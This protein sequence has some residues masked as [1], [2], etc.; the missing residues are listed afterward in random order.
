MDDYQRTFVFRVPP[1]RV[2]SA[3][4]EPQQ[5]QQWFT[6]RFDAADD[7]S[8]E[9]STSESPGGPVSFEVVEAKP[10]ARLQYRQWA[11][12]PDTGIDVTVTFE[13]VEHGTR[14]TVTQSG[15]GGESILRS[16]GV[17]NGMDEAYADLALYLDHGVSFPRHRDLPAPSSFGAFLR[18]TNAG[19]VVVAVE[20]DGF[21]ADAGLQP[22]DL[23]VQ[24]GRSGVFGNRELVTFLREHDPGEDA[25]VVWV[26][27]GALQRGRGR[28]TPRDEQVF[29][30][31]A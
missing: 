29:A 3:F 23:V 15:F 12:S 24:L 30:R 8:A 20:P 26:R 9:P 6:K 14:I 17:R 7:P 28:L 1:E 31:L 13:A 19:P 22:G 2:W 25:A 4:V 16:D 10:N 11:G 21:A 27:D 18:D 5:L